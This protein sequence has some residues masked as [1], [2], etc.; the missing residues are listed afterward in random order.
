MHEQLL[1]KYLGELKVYNLTKSRRWLNCSCPFA[2]WKHERGTD[3]RP[4]FGVMIAP[5]GASHYYCFTCKST[6][7]FHDLPAELGRFRGENYSAITR[8]IVM[9]EI[10][11]DLPWERE[12]EE[13]DE[14]EPLD[15][16]IYRGQIGRAHV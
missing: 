16:N 1:R 12:I 11:I 4:A 6:G 10:L 7:H 2:P 9:D 5:D 14:P 8:K 13:E 15:E 3:R